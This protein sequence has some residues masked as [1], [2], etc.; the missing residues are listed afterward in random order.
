MFRFLPLFLALLL[1]SPDRLCGQ[2]TLIYRSDQRALVVEVIRVT[3]EQVVAER[4]VDGR[5][6]RMTVPG[7]SLISV[8]YFDGTRRDFQAMDSPA[9]E[10]QVEVVSNIPRPFRIEFGLPGFNYDDVSFLG[11]TAG[12]YYRFQG[13]ELG[14]RVLNSGELCID[15]FDNGACDE[16]GRHTNL[17]LLYGRY[18]SGA[19]W[20]GALY[21]GVAYSWT[22]LL[23]YYDDEDGTFH[24]EKKING[25]GLPLGGHAILKFKG[26]W[27][28]GFGPYFLIGRKRSGGGMLTQVF[29][30]Q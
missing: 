30:V 21:T 14:L 25:F 9:V 28:L 23:D 10:E 16:L 11:L 22:K 1:S 6:L 2:D 13:N 29:F 3:N 18:W 4:E 27:G 5:L 19:K 8:R 7:D 12:L 24:D 20:E 15:V 26:K 17:A